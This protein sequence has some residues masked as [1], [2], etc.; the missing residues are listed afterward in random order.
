M[1]KCLIISIGLIAVHLALFGSDLGKWV[2]CSG[3][4]VVQNMTVEET[5]TLALKR[6]R[7]DAVEK[8]CGINLQTETLVHNF[9]MSSDFIHAFSY[10]QVVEEKDI[11]WETETIPSSDSGIAP[12]ILMRVS[13]N[14]RV[15]SSEEKPDPS[16]KL[17]LGLNRTVF[18]SGDEA[19]IMVQSTKD[20]YLTLLCLAANDSVYMLLPNVMQN[21]AF[22]QKG[23][24]YK[25]P[26]ASQRQ[27]GFHIR[28][29]TLPGHR[30]DSEMIKAIATRRPVTLLDSKA[31]KGFGQFGTPRMAV[32]KLASKLAEISPSERAEAS[33]GYTV[34]SK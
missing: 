26:D 24:K 22:I 30:S 8:A 23:V 16:F 15:V 19:I 17:S 5:Q 18:Q 10:G 1:K 4:A 32:I 25:I 6:A 31:E 12:L 13:M 3:E 7:Q 9:T 2:A 28:V 27:E 11:H 21:E 20:C 29:S 14:A 33:I 34:T